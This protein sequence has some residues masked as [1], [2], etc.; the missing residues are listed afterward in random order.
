MP[1]LHL[2]DSTDDIH[3]VYTEIVSWRVYDQGRIVIVV[4]FLCADLNHK[5]LRFFSQST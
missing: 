1:L 3:G 5:K 2:D 4:D